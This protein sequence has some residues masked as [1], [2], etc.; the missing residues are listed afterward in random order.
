[1]PTLPSLDLLTIGN[2]ALV[3]SSNNLVETAN[4]GSDEWI[5]ISSAYDR[6][7]PIMLAEKAWNFDTQIIA[8]DRIGDSDYPPFADVFAKPSD[9]LYI[10]KIWR[11]DYAAQMTPYRGDGFGDEDIRIPALDYRLVGDQVH[12]TA[13]NGVTAKYAVATSDPT[14]WTSLF[15]EA[16]RL[17]IK[18]TCYRSLNEDMS[19]A[20]KADAQAERAFQKAVQRSNSEEPRRV[21]FRSGMAERRRYGGGRA[22]LR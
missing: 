10:T 6:W 2:Q 18:A 17:R 7:W 4:D 9:S 21:G 14:H 12:T 20:D 11:T 19:E 15:A 22:V 13:P 3:D 5:A 8:L 16:L 1:M